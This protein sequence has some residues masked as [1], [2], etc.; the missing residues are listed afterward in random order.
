MNLV[1]S[2]LGRLRSKMEIAPMTARAN[3]DSASDFEDFR[4]S[5]SGLTEDVVIPAATMPAEHIVLR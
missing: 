3:S 2:V 4:P 1:P 5:V